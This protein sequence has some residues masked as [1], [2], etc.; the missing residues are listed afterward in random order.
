[1]RGLT[2]SGRVPRP[3]GTAV[4][5]VPPSRWNRQIPISAGATSLA[6]DRDIGALL[7][8]DGD[9]FGP[10]HEAD[11]DLLGQPAAAPAAAGVPR[12]SGPGCRSRP[13]PLFGH[14]QR[15]VLTHADLMTPALT[16]EDVSTRGPDRTRSRV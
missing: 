13:T 7:G 14:G 4:V 1:M 3:I 6:V 5:T 12:S 8:A 9:L 10:D 11:Q 2:T 16:L 15:A